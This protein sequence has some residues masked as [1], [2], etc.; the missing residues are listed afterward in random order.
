MVALLRQWVW[1]DLSEYPRHSALATVTTPKGGE[2]GGAHTVPQRSKALAAKPADGVRR[3]ERD[4]RD[5]RSSVLET[6]AQDQ[7]ESDPGAI[8]SNRQRPAHAMIMDEA[9]VQA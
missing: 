8:A 7:K 3:K 6:E 2:D 1:C 4:N 9:I 5:A